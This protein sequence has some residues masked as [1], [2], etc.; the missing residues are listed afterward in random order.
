M[1]M[2]AFSAKIFAALRLI[3]FSARAKSDLIESGGIHGL[4][5]S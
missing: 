2:F 3:L 1:N 4:G 5:E